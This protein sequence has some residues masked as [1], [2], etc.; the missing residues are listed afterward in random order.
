MPEGLHTSVEFLKG[1]GTHKAGLLSREL[2]ITKL[3]DLLYHF[4]FRYVDRS[5]IQRICDIQSEQA[6]IQLR[7]KITQTQL[8][9][10]ARA[11]RF[12]AEFSD[13]TGSVEL[14]WFRGVKWI[15]DSIRPGQEY[16]VFGKPARFKNYWSFAHPEI[17]IQPT[18]FTSGPKGLQA[19]YPGTEKLKQSG[20]DSK[21]LARLIKSVFERSDFYIPEIFTDEFMRKW[22]LLRRSEA[23]REIHFPSSQQQLT[24]AIYTFKFEELI[25]LHIKAGIIK[26]QRREKE[27]GLPFAK[28]GDN[29]NTFYNQYLPF[30][31]TGA[32]KRVIREIRKDMGSGK[33]M[34]RLLQGDVGSGKTIVCLI[35]ML[36]AADNGFQSVLMAPTEILATQH[37]KNISEMLGLMQVRVGL[38]K[39]STPA[40][41][42][43]KLIAEA[44]AGHLTILIG[45]HALL[46]DRVQF[47]QLGLVVIDEQHRFGVEQRSKLWNKASISP[48]V[49]VM[50]ATPIPR[51]LAMT[52]YGDL[53]VSVIDELPPGRK[54]IKTLHRYEYARQEIYM[55]MKEQIE[56]GRQVYIVYPLI[57]ESEKTDYQ[58]LMDGY[59]TVCRTFPL[60]RYQ[61]SVVHGRMKPADKDN[62]MERFVKHVTQIMVATTVI[63]VGVNVPNAS[64]MLIESAERF[65]LSQLHQLRGRVGRGAEQSYC[66]LLT[67]EKLSLDA[68]KR[69]Q[70]MV[71]T[72]DGFEIAEV[73]LALRGPGDIEGTRQSGL[74]DLKLTN[75]ATDQ[76]VVQQSR[77]AAMELLQQDAGL[78]KP[79]HGSLKNFL[80]ER[81]LFNDQ[82]WSRIS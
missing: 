57:E 11:Q 79:E 20:L 55:F 39:G 72:S 40:R 37:Y 38:L 24:N 5:T 28:I 19:I 59:D 26:L 16:L 49:L 63:E 7:G 46:E 71:R 70:T 74:L 69:I 34:N 61:V 82:E 76:W 35:C 54:P 18:G 64:I 6:Y 80:R 27:A 73:D 31:L 53:D 78:D 65:G 45:T 81:K 30:E 15:S 25:V 23:F 29:F 36:I 51:T 67:S 50:T 42:A 22:K 14:V 17:E 21:G 13:G 10:P 33:Q 58:S 41:E 68:R 3:I 52:V 8:T 75:L 12:V 77:D 1:V 47:K 4:P 43:R 9:G 32:Q 2:G 62:E 56:A 48:H 44:E 60:P 66:I